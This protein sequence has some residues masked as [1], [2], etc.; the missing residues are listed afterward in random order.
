MDKITLRESEESKKS[1]SEFF[2]IKQKDHQYELKLEIYNQNIKINILDKEELFIEYE[3]KLNLEELKQMH[4]IF[5]MFGTCKEFGDLIKVL[6]KNNKLNIQKII[7]SEVTIE[8]IVEYLY[9]QNTIKFVLPKKNINFEIIAKDIYKQISN[10]KSDFQKLHNEYK[11]IVKEN[12]TLSQERIE[13][14]NEIDSIK[15]K[16]KKLNDENNKIIQIVESLQNHIINLQEENKTL[17]KKIIKN[18]E[19]IENFLIKKKKIK[20]NSSIIENDEFIKIRS[21]VEEKMYKKIKEIKKLY[22]ASLD[23]GEPSIFHK[24]CDNIPNTLVLYKTK[25]NRRFGGYVSECWKSKGKFILDE[26]CFLFSLDR[27]KFYFS[28]NGNYYIISCN[29]KDGPSFGN[30]DK[31][32]IKIESNPLNNKSLKTNEL[33]HKELFDEDINAL[34]EDGKFEG[35]LAKEYEVF[36]IKF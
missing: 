9:Q 21:L 36:E 11:K 1:I 7:E 26:K 29:L 14:K 32:C 31:Y 33:F 10:L 8:L 35:I 15:T 27:N 6:I 25:G 2:D 20:I 5:L 13:I 16:N 3:L 23:G 30:K 28:K 19:T 17:N 34:S 4:K 18:N 24:K 12:Q 22:Q